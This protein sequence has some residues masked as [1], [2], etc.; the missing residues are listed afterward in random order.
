M[1]LGAGLEADGLIGSQPASAQ[2]ELA[3]FGSGWDWVSDSDAS[4][5]QLSPL[6]RTGWESQRM[7]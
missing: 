6:C 4:G 1:A 7:V 3:V 5:L 2:E